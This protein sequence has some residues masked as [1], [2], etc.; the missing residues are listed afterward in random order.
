MDGGDWYPFGKEGS[1]VPL[2]GKEGTGEIFGKIRILS[3]L[4][5]ATLLYVIE[6]IRLVFFYRFF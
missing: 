4:R 5:L 3:I 1:L 2:F 6:L